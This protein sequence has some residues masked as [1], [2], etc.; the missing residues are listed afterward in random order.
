M[1]KQYK[2]MNDICVYFIRNYEKKIS[3]DYYYQIVTHE[4]CNVTLFYSFYVYN[5]LHYCNKNLF[6][7]WFEHFVFFILT[8]ILLF[9]FLLFHVL[10]LNLKLSFYH[11]I[12]LI[13]CSW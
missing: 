7:L 5:F 1:F 12:F 2:C 4:I 9:W 10:N 6:V 8:F 13:A 11:F 3:H